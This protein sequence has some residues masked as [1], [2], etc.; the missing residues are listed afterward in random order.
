MNLKF[1]PLCYFCKHHNRAKSKRREELSV[2][3]SHEYCEAYPD[4]D[5][6]PIDILRRGHFKPK[7]GDQGL[8]FQRREDTS[9]ETVE[10]YRKVICKD[11]E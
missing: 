5:G 9:P 8:Q 1:P 4:G 10:F 2:W 3:F 7:D 6:I 11:E